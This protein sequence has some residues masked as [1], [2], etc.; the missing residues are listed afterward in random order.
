MKSLL[1]LSGLYSMLVLCAHAKEIDYPGQ[2]IT[3]ELTVTPYAPPVVIADGQVE[4]WPLAPEWWPA[5]DAQV[6]FRDGRSYEEW[7]RY[8]TPR[9]LEARR[10]SPTAFENMRQR[11]PN[12]FTNPPLRTALY[13]VEVG[14]DGRRVLLVPVVNLRVETVPEDLSELG[15]PVNVLVFEQAADGTWQNQLP[16]AV[17]FVMEIPYKYPAKLE[18][19]LRAGAVTYDHG[20]KPLSQ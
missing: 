12:A 13:Q 18:A 3:F 7:A 6:N 8:F 5:Y 16:R 9:A 10:A 2:G 4:D 19:I 15:V 14:W 20:M 17:G 1:L 11:P